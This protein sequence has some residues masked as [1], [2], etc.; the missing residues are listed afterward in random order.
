MTLCYEAL[1]DEEK[2]C[3]PEYIHPD[4]KK[5]ELKRF[6]Y[7]VYTKELEYLLVHKT[8]AKKNHCKKPY[9][10]HCSVKKHWTPI[11]T[12]L[13]DPDNPTH[14]PIYYK[15]ECTNK[16]SWGK[17]CKVCDKMD[18]LQYMKKSLKLP[19]KIPKDVSDSIMV[20]CDACKQKY[21]YYSS[22][23]DLDKSICDDCDEQCTL[24]HR[25]KDPR[26]F[27]EIYCGICT[28]EY[29]NSYKSPYNNYLCGK[30]SLGP[31]NCSMCRTW[32]TIIKE[33]GWLDLNG[34]KACRSCM[35]CPHSC[36][37]CYGLDTDEYTKNS[38]NTDSCVSFHEFVQCR[39]WGCF[40]YFHEYC[41]TYGEYERL[42]EECER[43]H[44]KYKDG[45][46]TWVD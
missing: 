35:T 13:Y 5:L 45:E 6:H 19:D 34:L 8:T 31:K 27:S 25:Y 14:L 28:K 37:A 12:S 32:E 39:R 20:E 2:D 16:Y 24:C 10:E 41:T 42:C 11:D 4:I 23:I 22:K 29:H 1:T 33:K 36:T 3:L 21:P 46:L 18:S 7:N 15:S 17:Q 44:V 43:N 30:C 38:C 9:G 40:E 26:T